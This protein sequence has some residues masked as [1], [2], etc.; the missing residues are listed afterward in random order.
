V[1]LYKRVKLRALFGLGQAHAA[2]ST[3]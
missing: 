3:R 2:N 1:I